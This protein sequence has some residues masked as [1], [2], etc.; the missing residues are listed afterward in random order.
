[1]EVEVTP[2]MIAAFQKEHARVWDSRA[3][4]EEE[5]DRELPLK[6][7]ADNAVRGGLW[8]A[9]ALVP[10]KTCTWTQSDEG[11]YWE[12]SCESG[13]L[14]TF[15]E[16]G[17]PEADHFNHCCYCGGRIIAIPYVEGEEE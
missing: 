14:F 13:N 4:L 16:D 3:K 5:L 10:E 15:S 9:L 8:A 17:E 2:Q 6:G 1:M 11:D 12:A 7:I